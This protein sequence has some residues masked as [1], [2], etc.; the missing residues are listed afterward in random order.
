MS[1]K[2]E[3]QVSKRRPGV[4]VPWKEKRAEMGQLTGD[5]AIVKRVWEEQEALAHMYI[6]HVLVSF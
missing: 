6:W 5:E 1:D 2:Q 4:C 3:K